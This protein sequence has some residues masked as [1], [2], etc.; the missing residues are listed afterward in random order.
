MA[1][2]INK[3]YVLSTYGKTS[4]ANEL[5]KAYLTSN[6]LSTNSKISPSIIRALDR[7][8]LSV[9]SSFFLPIN[10]SLAMSNLLVS[11]V[12]PV[13]V[14]LTASSSFAFT[15]FKSVSVLI[16]G[17]GTLSPLLALISSSPLL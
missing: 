9:S 15:G 8:S 5:C 1:T 14:D 12:F 16:P 13:H 3:L 4:Y 11:V 10:S 6:V 2:L 17:A 7:N